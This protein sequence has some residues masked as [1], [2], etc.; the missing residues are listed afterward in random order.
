MLLLRLSFEHFY[1]TKTL[2]IE[3]NMKTKRAAN[4][5]DARGEI[6]AAIS[7]Y[8]EEGATSS[9]VEKKVNLERHTLAKY[10]SIME[11]EGTLNYKQ[12]GKGRLWFVNKAPLQKLYRSQERTFT[13]KL[14]LNLT[15]KIP[16]GIVV[17]DKDYN[18][19][20]INDIVEEKYGQITGEKF[21]KGILG[22]KNQNQLRKLNILIEGDVTAA[23]FKITDRLENILSVKC[24]ELANPDGSASIIM[25][26]ED[27]T[28][29]ELAEEKLKESYEKLKEL[30]G[31]KSAIL[32]DV[33]RDLKQPVSLVTM[34][35]NLLLEEIKKEDVDKKKMENYLTILN[36]NSEMFEE[37][38]A[39]ILQLSR[40]ETE[41]DIEK[42]KVD[43]CEITRKVSENYT[44]AAE[45]KGIELKT[46][47]DA[48]PEI[49][50]NREL[51]FN[52]IKNM[53]SNA[54]KFTNRGYVEVDCTREN[55]NAVIS[56]K[57]TGIGIRKDDFEKIFQPFAKLDR[58]GEGIGVGL[59]ICKEIVSVYNGRID[60]DS[61]VGKGSTFTATIP[62][63]R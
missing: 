63:K 42:E 35:T 49:T 5:M 1:R 54:V 22:L 52:L 34:T 32:R 60:V 4:K 12:I 25:I 31:I 55:G 48:V 17:I 6:L 9:E 33:A 14:M 19:Q 45:D 8:G 2:V 57:D 46:K 23:K 15:S 26:V 58:S 3:G 10:L 39:A 62:L 44:K 41:R 56:V 47:I 21:Y 20:F 37:Q 13:E 43:I 24:S 30:D 18:I 51:I 38:L 29:K 40:V 27:I 16:T 50:A 53:V 36:K 59:A 7:G 28:D 11:R 61:A